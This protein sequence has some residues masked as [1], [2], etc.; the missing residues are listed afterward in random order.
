MHRFEVKVGQ[1]EG[2]LDLLL[3]LIQERK[4]LISDVSIASV[5]EDFITFVREH[6]SFPADQAAQFV[7]IAATLLLIK[8]RSL[9]PVL[10]LTEDEEENIDDLEYRLSLYKLFRDAGKK[11]GEATGRL[12]FGGLKKDTTPL[13]SPAPDMATPLLHAHMIAM[14]KHVPT[15]EKKKEVSVK[16]VVSLDEMMTRLAER[17]QKAFSMTF[18]DFVGTS[19]DKR[20]IVVGFLAVLELTKRG[21]MNVDQGA[22]F[23]DIVMNYTGGNDTPKYN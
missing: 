15:K 2:P 7:V 3:S 6:D 17:V 1:F 10:T 11:L 13:F 20:E 12:Y 5:A 22:H 4:M 16:S 9:L 21:L 18:K 8:S 14:L 19:E 23:S